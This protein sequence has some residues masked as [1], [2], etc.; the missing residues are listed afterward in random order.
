MPLEPLTVKQS[1]LNNLMQMIANMQ[2][3]VFRSTSLF[4]KQ[5]NT[6]QMI[7]EPLFEIDSKLL[8]EEAKSVF[9]EDRVTFEKTWR[10]IR[11]N[12]EDV[13]FTSGT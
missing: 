8:F 7:I 13:T 10:R 6:R 12:L 1:D 5:S 11:V 2:A 4:K 3:G 9:T